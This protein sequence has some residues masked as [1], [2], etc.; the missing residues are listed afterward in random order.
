MYLI[1]V[2]S[3]L[4]VHLAF[5]IKEIL[6]AIQNAVK[7][8]SSCVKLLDTMMANTVQWAIVFTNPTDTYFKNVFNFFFS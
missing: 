1:V 7:F 4:K 2:A 8:E 5:A 3:R 6:T